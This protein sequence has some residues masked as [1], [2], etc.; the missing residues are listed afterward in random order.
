MKKKRQYKHT[1][2]RDKQSIIR[3]L[4]TFSKQYEYIYAEEIELD[5]NLKPMNLYYMDIVVDE[6]LYKIY[7]RIDSEID[8]QD[9]DLM[10]KAIDSLF[11]IGPTEWKEGIKKDIGRF[12][13]SNKINSFLSNTHEENVKYIISEHSSNKKIYNYIKNYV[14]Y[15]RCGIY[16][17]KKS[18]KLKVKPIIT[19]ESFEKR[20]DYLT[21]A[22]EIYLDVF[23][24]IKA[25][26][27]ELNDTLEE[28]K[29]HPSFDIDAMRKDNDSYFHPIDDSQQGKT[30][31]M[32][33]RE[34]SGLYNEETLEKI[35]GWEKD[36]L[37]LKKRLDEK[38]EPLEHAFNID[39]TIDFETMA[40]FNDFSTFNFEN[41]AIY[42]IAKDFRNELQYLTEIPE[43][44]KSVIQEF[45]SLAKVYEEHYKWIKKQ[46]QTWEGLSDPIFPYKHKLRQSI[47]EIKE[48]LSSYKVKAS[49]KKLTE[50]VLMK[51]SLKKE[52]LDDIGKMIKKLN[53]ILECEEEKDY[54]SLAAE[55]IEV[56][57]EK[58]D[59]YMPD[60]DYLI[61][62]GLIEDEDEWDK[63]QPYLLLI[64]Y[65]KNE[66]YNNE[67]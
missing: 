49:F 50:L 15:Y 36:V 53:S 16:E 3:S 25:E 4:S 11:G 19:F 54:E 55:C 27:N 58:P 22:K 35:H 32:I 34:K 65:E 28:W 30:L 14:K 12:Q 41:S 57:D 38:L 26:Y 63:I 56:L 39:F 51:K 44:Y 59:Y 64:E 13:M 10:C 8:L 52:K 29:K 37:R 1:K 46:I 45:L 47:Y 18:K 42:M 40:N 7:S 20:L 33:E 60:F 31:Y 24:E 61:E 5:L 21:S 17:L 9:Y 23:K 62:C 6:K 2:V 48:V 67:I 66:N 43:K